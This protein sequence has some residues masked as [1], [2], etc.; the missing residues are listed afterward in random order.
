MQVYAYTMV[1]VVLGFLCACEEHFDFDVMCHLGCFVLYFYV[2]VDNDSCKHQH[3]N[4]R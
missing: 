3:G 1:L 2:Y 4:A